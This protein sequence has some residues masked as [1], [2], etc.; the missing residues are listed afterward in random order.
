MQHGTTAVK[1]LIAIDCIIF[2][3]VTVVSKVLSTQ[4]VPVKF[5]LKI[6]NTSKYNSMIF[7]RIAVILDCI[8][9]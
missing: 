2:V 6:R 9:S 7:N 4:F 1:Y 3:I 8:N 5:E